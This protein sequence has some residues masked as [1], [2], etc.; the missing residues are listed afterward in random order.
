MPY[1]VHRENVGHVVCLERAKAAIDAQTSFQTVGL[2]AIGAGANGRMLDNVPGDRFQESRFVLTVNGNIA[3]FN[4]GFF[5]IAVRHD[6]DEQPPLLEFSGAVYSNVDGET[7]RVAPFIALATELNPSPQNTFFTAPRF[8][9]SS[10]SDPHQCDWNERI[11][12]DE[13]NQSWVGTQ[14]QFVVAG[15]CVI[16]VGSAAAP[17]GN[18]FGNMSLRADKTDIAVY[19]ANR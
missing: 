12:F 2:A 15:V 19:D 10:P 18:H 9:T 1:R 4:G 5:G 7:H 8:L 11:I 17:F 16:N 13:F 6:I 3:A 14:P